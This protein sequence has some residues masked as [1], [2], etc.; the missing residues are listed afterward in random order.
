MAVDVN[1]ANVTSNASYWSSTATEL[2]KE[3]QVKYPPASTAL[4]G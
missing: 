3:I 1:A 4:K 2:V